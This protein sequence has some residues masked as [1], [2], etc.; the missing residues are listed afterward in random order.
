MNFFDDDFGLAST[1]LY[2][3]KPSYS[4]DQ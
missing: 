2:T 4:G 1:P 3:K